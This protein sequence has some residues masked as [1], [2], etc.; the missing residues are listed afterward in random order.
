VGDFGM[1]GEPLLTPRDFNSLLLRHFISSATPLNLKASSESAQTQR[2]INTTSTQ[3]PPRA[4]ASER[5]RLNV[6]FKSKSNNYTDKL[7]TVYYFVKRSE[8]PS[9]PPLVNVRRRCAGEN[10]A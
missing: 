6:N 1:K 4:S 7:S 9:F 2:E 3:P 5:A 10:C 8:T